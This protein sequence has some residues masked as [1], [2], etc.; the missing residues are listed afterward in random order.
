MVRTLAL[1]GVQAIAA[2][3]W[4][5][6][7]SFSGNYFLEVGPAVTGKSLSAAEL[8]RNLSGKILAT[9]SQDAIVFVAAVP[10][11]RG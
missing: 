11:L 4:D 10:L 2:V 8:G 3:A 5:L 9:A 1:S 7:A 6:W